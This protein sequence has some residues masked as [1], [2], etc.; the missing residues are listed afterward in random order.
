MDN[1]TRK[2]IHHRGASAWS[3]ASTP[4]LISR[5]AAT[6]TSEGSGHSQPTAH[7]TKAPS[8]TRLGVTAAI[9]TQPSERRLSAAGAAAAMKAHLEDAMD[10]AA[11]K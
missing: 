11:R 6:I 8:A 7:G 1:G 9:H 2:A 3:L 10:Y 4:R 5:A